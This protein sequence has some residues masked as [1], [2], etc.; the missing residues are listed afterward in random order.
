MERVRPVFDAGRHA[1]EIEIEPP[2]ENF[3]GSL[4][5]RSEPSGTMLCGQ[6]RRRSDGC[7]RLRYRRRDR[8]SHDGLKR[9]VLA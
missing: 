9:P 3:A 5:L 6:E 7:S 2:H 4:V 8:R 1:N